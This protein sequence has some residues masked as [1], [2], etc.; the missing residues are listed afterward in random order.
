MPDEP[1]FG[2]R[3]DGP[4][5]RRRAVRERVN[6]AVSLFS[7]DQ[8]RVALLADVSQSGCRLSGMGLPG[9]GDDILLKVGELELFGE[10]VWKDG[11]ERGVQF[12]EPISEHD[13]EALRHAVARQ[14]GQEPRPP[15]IIPPAGR[16]QE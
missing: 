4:T 10:I 2:R 7:I 6:I 12:E 14:Q 1:G 13:L 3:R 15:D 9:I 8:S 11:A 5:G 16:R